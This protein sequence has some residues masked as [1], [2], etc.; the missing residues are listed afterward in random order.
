MGRMALLC[1]ETVLEALAPL[2]SLGDGLYG[3]DAI[4]I[5]ARLPPGRHLCPIQSQVQSQALKSARLSLLL[6]QKRFPPHWCMPNLMGPCHAGCL[7]DK[8]VV[9]WMVHEHK[10]SVIPGS[11]CGCPGYVR[12]AFGKP[13]PVAFKEAA[14]RLNAALRQLCSEGFGVVKQWQKSKNQ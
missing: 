12:V 10:V 6:K 9:T 4:Y 2:G 5:W 1:R 14:A 8:A 7:D 3:G 13:E 11:G